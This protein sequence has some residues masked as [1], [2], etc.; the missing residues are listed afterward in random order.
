MSYT[1]KYTDDAED[2]IERLRKSGN[3]QALDFSIRQKRLPPCVRIA[4]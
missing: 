1:I 2:D 3:K 4:W